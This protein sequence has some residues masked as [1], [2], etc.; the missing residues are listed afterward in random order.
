MRH[1][2]LLV[3]LLAIVCTGCASTQLRYQRRTSKGGGG[4]PAAAGAGQPGDVCPGLQ[5]DA[6]FLLRQ[7][8]RRCGHRS[9]RHERQR[10]FHP[11][12]QCFHEHV[13]GKILDV[14]L[15]RFVG[16][17]R[18]R[19]LQHAFT[20]T[21][22]NDPRKLELMHCA[23]QMAVHSCGRGAVSG[24][25]PDCAT[26]F[27]MFYTGD[28][29]GDIRQG[30]NGT[31]TSEC[32]NSNCCWFHAGCKKCAPKACDCIL[33]G[34]Y[35]GCFVWVTEEGRDELTKLTLAIL[36]YALNNPPQKRTK[37]IV[38]NVNEY[39]LP[40]T[41]QLA[42]GKVTA[43]V[44]ID[45]N[46]EALLKMTQDEEVRIAD[47]LDYR[48][49]RV[50]ERLATAV[51]PQEQKQ[52]LDEDQMLQNKLDFLHNQMRQGGLKEQFYPKSPIPS[53]A[54]VLQFDLQQNALTPQN[55]PIQGQ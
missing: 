52:L 43:N 22:V 14:P 45:E 54:G 53:N 51:N 32:L 6:V 46:P 8:K 33:V 4:L 12:E 5:L 37:E 35:C 10:H 29:N 28:P 7:S 40:T 2:Y 11:F 13:A 36:N 48:H 44:A 19:S 9:G 23:Y 34:E 49:Q 42:V 31:I 24:T 50:K 16:G 47:F 27:K 39:G 41:N 15:A 26:R 38:Y 21:P 3:G 20:I 30:A 25:C 17:K 1:L 18:R 55:P